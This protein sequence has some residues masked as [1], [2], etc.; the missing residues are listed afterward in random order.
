MSKLS[1][2]TPGLESQKGSV[3]NLAVAAEKTDKPLSTMGS[4]PDE[5][6]PN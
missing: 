6:M 5:E 2:K 4:Q 3:T 1:K